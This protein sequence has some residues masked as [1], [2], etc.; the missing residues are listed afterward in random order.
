MIHH[1]YQP[2]YRRAPVINEDGS[3]LTGILHPV[4]IFIISIT[5]HDLLHQELE[6]KFNQT[7]LLPPL[8]ALESLLLNARNGLSFQEQ[9]GK[10][11]SS[12]YQD[13]FNFDH[14]QRH[15]SLLVD[16]Y[17][18]RNPMVKKVTSIR[19]ICEAMNSEPICKTML[20]EVHKLFRLYITVPISSATSERTFSGLKHILT[21]SRASM[22]EHR[23]NSC[24]LPHIHKQLTDNCDLIEVTRQFCAVPDE[25]RK[26]FGAFK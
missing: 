22:T 6:K 10:V 8:P 14:L 20:S 17:Q 26:H 16:A 3:F 18:A 2:C 9:L 12:C 7:D 5:R 19:T 1:V 21:Y 13:D 4:N 11:K 25:C 15:L 24:L 23:L